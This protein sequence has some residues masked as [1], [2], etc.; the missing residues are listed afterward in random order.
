MPEFSHEMRPFMLNYA[1]DI[2]S[3]KPNPGC[4]LIPTGQAYLT[5]PI[6]Y[7]YECSNCHEL[8]MLDGKYPRI[9]HKEI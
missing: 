2:C 3:Q 8:F 4:V 1:C 5:N 7:Q 6:R 9:I